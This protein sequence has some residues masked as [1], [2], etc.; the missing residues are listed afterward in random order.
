MSPRDELRGLIGRL[1]AEL[2]SIRNTPAN[3]L[4]RSDRQRELARALTV[5]QG[6]EHRDNP[7]SKVRTIPPREPDDADRLDWERRL[8]DDRTAE[9]P[10]PR[11]DPTDVDMFLG[12]PGEDAEIAPIDPIA[13]IL[14]R[15]QEGRD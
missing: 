14:R 12:V 7:T 2:A 4:R 13:M 10:D 5:L 6:L 11:L 9:F 1:E 3:A 8:A 15:C